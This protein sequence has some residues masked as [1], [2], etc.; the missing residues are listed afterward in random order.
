MKMTIL[1]LIA[2]AATC[3]ITVNAMA[4]SGSVKIDRGCVKKLLRDELI[5]AECNQLDLEG[6]RVRCVLDRVELIEFA[7]VLGWASCV[8]EV[9]NSVPELRALI[10]ESHDT[11]VTCPFY[12]D[13]CEIKV[14]EKGL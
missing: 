3:L 11:I 2:V 1:S 7:L 8:G 14:T 6:R 4:S 5:S 13:I 10:D 9:L 12:G